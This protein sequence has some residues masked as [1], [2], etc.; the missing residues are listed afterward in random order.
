MFAEEKGDVLGRAS[1]GRG[2]M[3]PKGF[4]NGHGLRQL[5]GTFGTETVRVSQVRIER[6]EGKVSEWRSKAMSRCTAE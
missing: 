2:A 5:V 3:R 4:R 6:E 1:Y